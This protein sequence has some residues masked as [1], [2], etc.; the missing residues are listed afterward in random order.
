VPGRRRGRVRRP[1]RRRMVRVRSRPQDH[2]KDRDHGHD[3]QRQAT[4]PG[5]A[6]SPSIRRPASPAHADPLCRVYPLPTPEC[7]QAALINRRPFRAVAA[8]VAAMRQKELRPAPG[9]PQRRQ[10][11]SR[12]RTSAR[13]APM[14]NGTWG[15]RRDHPE[16]RGESWARRSGPF[17]YRLAGRHKPH[18]TGVCSWAA[19]GACSVLAAHRR[20][21]GR[22]HCSGCPVC[23]PDRSPRHRSAAG[24]PPGAHHRAGALTS[25]QLSGQVPS[26]GQQPGQGDR[27]QPLPGQA[28]Q[29]RRQGG[30]G[31]G[32]PEMQAY[33]R[34]P[35]HRAEHGGHDRLRSGIGV[36]D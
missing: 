21:R 22:V 28:V 2:R 16:T 33:D 25:P 4:D 26:Q 23:N 6:P 36:V 35:P 3:G 10:P 5:Q 27:A 11:T 8:P 7:H 31:A 14:P 20:H 1:G 13:H 17:W 12:S 18:S 29:N 24:D 32:M 19:P 34:P 15:P 9:R 30:H